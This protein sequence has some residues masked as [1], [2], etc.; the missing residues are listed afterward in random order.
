MCIYL[1]TSGLGCCLV[2]AVGIFCVIP[3][4]MEGLLM[5]LVVVVPNSF[6]TNIR[7]VF[8]NFAL[9]LASINLRKLTQ[10]D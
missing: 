5:R 2:Y 3:F 6:I 9:L 8:Q 7:L 1:T 4:L 10:F